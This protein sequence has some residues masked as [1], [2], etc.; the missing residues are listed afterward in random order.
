[1]RRDL[2]VQS[3]L[4]HKSDLHFSLNKLVGIIHDCYFMR[5]SLED[6]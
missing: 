2:V 5:N 1:M 4:L 3:D 6:L